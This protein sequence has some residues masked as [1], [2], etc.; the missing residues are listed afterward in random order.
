[1]LLC[2]VRVEN[3]DIFIDLK[4]NRGGTY[5]K[6]SERNGAGRNTVLI[7]SSGIAKLRSVLDEVFKVSSKAKIVSRE[8]KSRA[9]GDPTLVARSVYVSGLSWD[10]TEEELQHYFTKVYSPLQIFS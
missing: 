7:P 4:K 1:M 10:T 2:R 3:K 5:L 8:R 9:A 6:I